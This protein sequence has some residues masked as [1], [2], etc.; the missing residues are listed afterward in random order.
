MNRVSVYSTRDKMKALIMVSEQFKDDFPNIEEIME[1]VGKHGVVFGV[2]AEK[3]REFV[4]QKPCG[5]KVVVAEGKSV[6]HGVAGKLDFLVELSDVGKPQLLANGR[7][8]HM[9]LKK[10]VNVRKGQELIRRIPPTPGEDGVTVLGVGIRPPEPEDVHLAPG[11]GTEI[12]EKDPN[13]LIASNDGALI[14]DSGGLIEVRTSRTIT[15]DIDYSTGNITFAGD[16][17][18][19]GSVRSGFSV[20]SEGKLEIFGS[21]ED[22]TIQSDSEIDIRGG[23]SGKKKGLITCRG[24][25]K[26]KHLENFKVKAHKDLS[27]TNSILHSDIYSGGY[28]KAGSVIGGQVRVTHGLQVDEIGTESG[29]KT[30]IMIGHDDHITNLKMELEEEIENLAVTLCDKKEE[31][32]KIVAD[33]MGNDG[34][35]DSE[36]EESLNMI[37]DEI[38]TLQFKSIDTQE[39]LKKVINKIE[40]TPKP[41]IKAGII[42]PN[43]IFCYGDSEMVISTEM[44]N[45]VV[46]I[47]EGKIKI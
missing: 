1:V 5:N 36:N 3:I 35:L 47:E 24:D 30:V 12:S 42:N 18:I 43:T 40:N 45:R 11:V 4:K 14:V 44:R 28:I 33:N 34:H 8:D 22:A 19:M 23:A 46:A 13:I 39:K 20:S 7:V 21:I 37:K 38:K 9:E 10:L 17:K 29:V 25:V 41:E 32:Y 6:T 31:C 26:V 2:D 27:V 15:S 16:L